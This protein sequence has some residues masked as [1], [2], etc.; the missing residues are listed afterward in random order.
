M[1]ETKDNIDHDL[2][3]LFYAAKRV[4]DK[5]HVES[6]SSKDGQYIWQRCEFV[7]DRTLYVYETINNNKGFLHDMLMLK[8]FVEIYEESHPEILTNDTQ[9]IS[10]APNHD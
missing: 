3:G 5:L 2:Q 10:E 1:S 6:V 4:A 9:Q 7:W 8:N